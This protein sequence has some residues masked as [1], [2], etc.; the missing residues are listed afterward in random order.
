MKVKR[1]EDNKGNITV[2]G[3]PEGQQQP[4]FV[5]GKDT[6]RVVIG[7]TPSTAA[8]WR[9]LGIGPEYHSIGGR[10]YYEYQVLKEFFSRNKVVTTGDLERPK[11]EVVKELKA[12]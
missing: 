10:V 11:Q 1:G 5:A 9:A 4:L 3:F 7:W 2:I 12:I 8:N 6:E